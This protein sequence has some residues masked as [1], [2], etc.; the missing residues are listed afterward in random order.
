MAFPCIKTVAAF[1]V[2]AT[3]TKQNLVEVGMVAE[4]I[5]AFEDHTCQHLFL[6]SERTQGRDRLP[7]V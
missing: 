7:R 3:N 5:A 2:V 1:G 4:K 6:W